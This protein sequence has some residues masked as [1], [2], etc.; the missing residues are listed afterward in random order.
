MA[1]PVVFEALD[2]RGD[3]EHLGLAGRSIGA[4]DPFVLDCREESLADRIAPTI[5]VEAD[6]A[7]HVEFVQRPT[8]RQDSVRRD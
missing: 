2:V 8:P 7:H 3:G 4:V 1:S 6:A 5:T